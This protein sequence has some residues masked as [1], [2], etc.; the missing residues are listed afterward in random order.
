MV[1]GV[2]VVL[3]DEGAQVFLEVYLVD[4]ALTD[5]APLFAIA[6]LPRRVA[7]DTFDPAAFVAAFWA[8]GA[9]SL[10]RN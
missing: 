8:A 6:D 2:D 1:D 3:C 4:D 5:G 7:E 9:P 10:A